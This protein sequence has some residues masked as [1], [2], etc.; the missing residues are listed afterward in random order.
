MSRLLSISLDVTKIPRD[1]I[2][3]HENGAKYVNLDVW[4]NDEEDKYGNHASVSLKQTKEERDAK[5]KKTYIGNGKKLFGF[6]DSKPAQ[7]AHNQA[8]SNG[9]QP[10]DS[11]PPF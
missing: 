1:Q 8:K 7:S 9:Y 2:K 11:N 5:A 4:I 6:G 10:D 3:S